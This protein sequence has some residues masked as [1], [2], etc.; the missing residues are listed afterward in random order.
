MRASKSID[1]SRKSCPPC[2]S[3]IR[4]FAPRPTRSVGSDA[5]WRDTGVAPELPTLKRQPAA[6]LNQSPPIGPESAP[7]RRS[8]SS[9]PRPCITMVQ[10]SKT[11]FAAMRPRHSRWIE[12]M[13]RSTCPFCRGDRTAV[14]WSRMPILLRRRRMIPLYAKSLSWRAPSCCISGVS[15]AAAVGL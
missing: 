13:T 10:S 11:G 4:D 15:F 8:P 6:S 3:L 9:K 2:A 14:G 7:R 5:G 1:V 12:P